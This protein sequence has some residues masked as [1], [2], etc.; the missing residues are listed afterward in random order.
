MITRRLHLLE[1]H[2]L[3]FSLL[4]DLQEI[5]LTWTPHPSSYPSSWSPGDYTYL[6]STSLCLPFSVITRRLHLL[7]L[8]ILCFSLLCDLQGITLTWTPHPLLFPSLW[9]PGDY[10]Y[11]NATSLILPFFMISRRLHLLE[12][13]IPHLALLHDL[14][15]IT[16]TWTPHPFACP[17]LWSPGDY[18]YLNST[19][20][21]FPFSVISRRLHLLQLHIPLLALLCDLQEI[22]FTLT[23]HPSSFPPLWSPGDVWDVRCEMC[24]Y[25]FYGSKLFCH[26]CANVWK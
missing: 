17:S 19:S 20:F 4:S 11:L 2:I 5:T 22:T 6:N 18:T 9:S 16:L 14:Q 25:M 10:T 8:H 7:E 12:L 13:H 21:A 26:V 3:C 24:E 1:L 15:E 23:P